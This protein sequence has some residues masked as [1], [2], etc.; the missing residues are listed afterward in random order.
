MNKIPKTIKLYNGVEIPRIGLGVWKIDNSKVDQVISWAI[1]TGYRHID[2]ACAYRN[3][4]GVGLGIRQSNLNRQDIFVTTKLAIQD[5][6]KPEKAFSQS[7]DKLKTGYIDLYLLHWPFLNWKNAW[8]SLENIY[9]NGQ[10]KAIGV[11]NFS[12]KQ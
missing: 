11:S 2:T 4:N 7:L 9:K 5:F 10:A 1:E 12:I 3:E 6:F 8:K